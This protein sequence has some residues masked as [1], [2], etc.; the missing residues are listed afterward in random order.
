MIAETLHLLVR[1]NLAASVAIA[2]VGFLRRPVRSAFGA[3]AAYRLWAIPLVM[4]LASLVPIPDGAPIAPIVLAAARGLPTAA[5]LRSGSVWPAAVGGAWALGA[6]L[7]AA[8]L[9]ARQARFVAALRNGRPASIGG[10]S[11]VR[12]P[13]TDMGPAVVVGAI[14]LPDD[15]EV[16]FTADEQAAILAHEAQHLARGDVIANAVIALVQCIC[17]FNPLIHLAARCVRFDQELAC[18]AAAIADRPGMRRPYAEA[19]LKTQLITTTPPI[20][21][22]WRAGGFP[23]LRDRIRLLDQRA[24]SAPRRVFG[25]L[26][27]AALTLAGGYA[28]WATQTSPSQSVVKPAWST[29]PNGAD[30]ARFYPRQALARRLEGMA[31]MRCRVA[32]TGV[33]SGCVIVREDPRGGGF[34][35]A[36][37]QMAPLFRMLP[38]TVNGTPVARAIIHIPVQFKLPPSGAG[39]S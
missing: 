21:C 17:W 28:A 23:A 19:L 2:A 8:M 11:V 22:A 33:L 26:L 34:G 38:G 25:V 30:F 12:A 7:F 14:I 10:R 32:L 20:G 1:A 18:D 37:L 13:W 36:A 31:V 9:A 16:R 24:P 4:A 3:S 29:V 5:P 27:L 39:R 6:F 35:A 15:F